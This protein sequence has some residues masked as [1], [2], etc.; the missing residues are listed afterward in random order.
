MWI[1]HFLRVQT[2]YIKYIRIIHIQYITNIL[3]Y[4]PCVY[5]LLQNKN[6]NFEQGPLN[7]YLAILLFTVANII[8]LNIFGIKF[9]I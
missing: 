4:I 2:I 8:F 6:N 9:E 3:I 5:I 7:A 1:K